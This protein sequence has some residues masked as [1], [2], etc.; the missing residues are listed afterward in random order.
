MASFE[1]KTRFKKNQNT[2][3]RE[4]DLGR[5]QPQDREIE[6]AV[7]GGIMLEKDAYALVNEILKPESFY[8][9]NHKLIYTA[10]RDLYNDQKPI[11]MLTV[12]DKLKSNGVL[13]QVG[14]AYAIAQLTMRVLSA[15]NIEYH[16]RIIAQK[17]LAREL[18]RFSSEVQ[19]KA[20]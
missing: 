1:P 9:D 10:I 20:F 18:I 17:Y 13:E 16:A 6:E 4:L 19:T 7:L 2:P 8:D 15:A 3:L 12:T 11:D 5:L 14:G